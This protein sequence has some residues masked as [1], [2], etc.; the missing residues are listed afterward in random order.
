MA[1]RKKSGLPTDLG[2]AIANQETPSFKWK[3]V[4]QIG[5]AFAVLWVTSFIVVPFV[6]YWAVYVVALLTVIAIGFG[7]YVWRLTSRSRAIVDIMK[8]ATD[9]EGRQKALDELAAGGGKDAMK[10]LAHAQLLAQTDPAAAQKVL[11]DI[12]VKKAPTVLQDDV[13][14]QLAML[15]LRNNRIREARELADEVR[16]DR[17]PDA[18]TKGLYAAIIAESFA[19]T[20][21]EGEARKLLE[22]Y[23]PEAAEGDEVRAMLLRAQVYTYLAQKKRGRAEQAMRALAAIEPNL[24]AAF[25]MKGSAP[26]AIKLARQVLGAQAAPKMQMQRKR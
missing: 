1:K 13:R 24:V 9:E 25:M 4:L 6:G 8:G 20:G 14:A 3:A 18:K 23:T 19:R 16:L 11:E 26:E 7:I 2:E 5:G 17:R 22:T 15:Y 10:A 12:D 21:S